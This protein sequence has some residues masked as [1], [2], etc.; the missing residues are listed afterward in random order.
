MMFRYIIYNP[1]L[2]NG[3]CGF[4]ESFCSITTRQSSSGKKVLQ[5]QET[6]Q[7]SS[8][9]TL[10]FQ[11]SLEETF[12]TLNHSPGIQSKLQEHCQVRRTSSGSFHLGSII[13]PV[14]LVFA[15]A[16]DKELDKMQHE[17]EWWVW[18]SGKDMMTT[19]RY[20]KLHVQEA[21]VSLWT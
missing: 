9:W 17:E 5:A 21:P 4:A 14:N 11:S 8:T 19:I 10:G 15:K 3:H 6:L 7:R 2:K 13:P 18:A 1:L 12:T 20:W 16:S